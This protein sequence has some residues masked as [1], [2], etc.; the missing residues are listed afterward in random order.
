M[1]IWK[2]NSILLTG[3]LD[4]VIMKIKI[5][6]YLTLNRHVGYC[7]DWKQGNKQE[8]SNAQLPETSIGIKSSSMDITFQLNKLMDI[9]YFISSYPPY[10]Y[11]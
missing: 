2:K 4:S 8:H 6:N 7:L 5:V 11:V 1:Y 9:C 3:S 10:R